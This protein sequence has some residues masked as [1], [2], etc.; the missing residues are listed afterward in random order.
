[1][2]R[3][4][5]VD[6]NHQTIVGALEA[7]GWLVWSTAPLGRGFPDVLAAKAGRLV[8][9]EIKDGAK[10]PS[11]RQ[12]TP[13]ELSAHVKFRLAGVHVHVVQRVADL[14]QIDREARE[15]F[16]TPSLGDF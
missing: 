10:S 1:V 15:Q 11:R 16:E 9:I 3:A 4:A 5:K 2:R 8:L 13:D 14:A 6:D 12:L 7:L